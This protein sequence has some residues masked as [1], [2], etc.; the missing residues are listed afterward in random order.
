MT[1]RSAGV[2]AMARP[3]PLKPFSSTSA[4]VRTN[5]SPTAERYVVRGQP[6]K[7]D[8]AP[9]E[10]MEA[11]MRRAWID[12]FDA[13]KAAGYEKRHLVKTTVCV[14]EGGHLQLFRAMRDRMMRGHVA[15]SAYLHVAGFG[16]P[17]HLVEIEGELVRGA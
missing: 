10:G 11:Q 4:V 8:G 2:N 14:T 13:I 1:A 15:A 12:L 7:Q 6:A 5:G 9:E 17:S 3:D 16:A